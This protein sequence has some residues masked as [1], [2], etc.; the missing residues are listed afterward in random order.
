MGDQSRNERKAPDP[1]E[2]S[3]VWIDIA[4]KSQKIVSEFVR[5]QQ[6]KCHKEQFAD[7]LNVSHAF[8]EFTRQI[9][10]DPTKLAQNQ[11]ALWQDYMALWQNT[12]DKIAGKNT[13]PVISPSQSDFR[14]RDKDWHENTIFDF[15]K[16]SYLL[17]T[18]WMQST[19]K[20][21]EG[22]DDKT[23]QKLDFYTRQFADAMA[24]TN[25]V[26]TNPKVLKETIERGGQNLVQGLDN[27]IEDLENSEDQLRIKM[28]E[29]D[30][31]ELGRDIA[32]SPGK[33]VYQNDLLQLIQYN[34]TTPTVSKTPLLIMPPWINKYYILDLQEKNS[35]VKWAIDQGITIFMVSWV[36]PDEKL[37]EKTFEDYIIEGPLACLEA[38]QAATG[39]AAINVIGYCLGGTLLAATLALLE[40][41]SEKLKPSIKSAT[42]FTTMVDFERAGELGVFI[43]EE[44]LTQLEAK[45]NNQGYL[46]GTEMAA[47]FNM[48]RAND[49]IWSFV[50]NNYLMGR[51]PFPFDLLFWNSDSTRMPAAMHSF[52][53][54]KMYLENKLIQKDALNF[55][56]TPIDLSRIRTPSFILSARDDHIA[57]WKSTYAAMQIFKGPV[58]FCLATSGHI[59]GV[60]NPPCATK[61]SY[62]SNSKNPV[63]PEVWLEDATECPGSW[64]PEWAE[65]L[66]KYSGAEIKARIPGERALDVIEDAPGS[67]VLTRVD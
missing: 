45:M 66:K 58:R 30:A 35:F 67:Y 13:D 19:V 26:M 49:L 43:D 15:I 11:L 55:C 5:R 2:Y 7:P 9:M 48:L 16:Q 37:S 46:K 36:N 29:E 10:S 4:S 61:Y 50:I 28:V 56:G 64:W 44:Q 17:T 47:T 38:I 39:E 33:I 57:P 6:A 59:A 27:L 23:M 32:I 40:R 63:T 51:D 65:W 25:F 62:W 20:N 41:K 1:I 8:I 31:F 12:A 3:R 34:P 54:R 21:T 42:F 24:P 14:F 53:L 18:R 60:I 22:L 52:Y